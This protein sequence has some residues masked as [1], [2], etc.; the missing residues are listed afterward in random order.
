[1]FV[2]SMAYFIWVY[3]ISTSGD[4]MGIFVAIL[5]PIYI[6]LLW[7]ALSIYAGILLFMCDDKYDFGEIS[8]IILL[9]WT[10][11]PYKLS[12]DVC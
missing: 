8:L 1:M 10:Y 7:V 4:G 9:P 5:I 12:T 3:K 6:I 11:I 2:L